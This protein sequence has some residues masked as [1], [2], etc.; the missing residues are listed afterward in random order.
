MIISVMVFGTV[1]L[2]V[3]NIPL[4]AGEI[5]LSRAIIAAILIITYQLINRKKINENNKHVNRNLN[6]C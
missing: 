2:F 6:F 4:S 3:K 1:G 5:A